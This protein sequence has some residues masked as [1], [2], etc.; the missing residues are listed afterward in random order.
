M[1]FK[2]TDIDN[3]SFFQ[4]PKSLFTQKN[5][6]GLGGDAKIIY[7][8]LKDRMSLS[9]RNGWKDG[10]GDIFLLFKQKHIADLLGLSIATIS[11][12]MHQ[13][14]TYKLI[15]TVRQG[16]NKPNKIYI[17]KIELVE[18]ADIA[19]LD[20]AFSQECEESIDKIS[21]L[22][23]CK[24]ELAT[25][26]IRTCNSA[27][28][29]LQQRKSGL[30]AVQTNNTEISNTENNYINNNNNGL[31]PDFPNNNPEQQRCDDVVVKFL[32]SGMTEKFAMRLIRKFGIDAVRKQLFN[33]QLAKERKPIKNL[34]GWLRTALEE[35]FD[36]SRPYSFAVVPQAT[37]Q[38][39]L[40]PMQTVNAGRCLVEPL[41]P[42][43]QAYAEI[44]ATNLAV[45]PASSDSP[46]WEFAHRIKDKK[47]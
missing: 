29:D 3:E 33:F 24:S 1:R 25:A 18:E 47:A 9:R 15:E 28:Q 7:S 16:L 43:A 36:S 41:S 45:L 13:L 38:P 34:A 17:N 10:N 22:Q 21:D 14:E 32:N 27:N 2:I 4:L 6:R 23:Q 8:L 26:Q 44:C 20:E 40:S 30:A 5:Y 37:Y 35:D 31:F 42:E 46:F 39:P 11:R 12:A 19:D